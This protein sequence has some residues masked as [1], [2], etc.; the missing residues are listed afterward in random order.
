MSAPVKA[1]TLAAFLPQIFARLGDM[2]QEAQ[3]GTLRGLTLAA[4]AAP[5][6][7]FKAGALYVAVL[8]RAGQPLP[9]AALQQIAGELGK[10][11]H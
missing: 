1:E 4:G 11:N 9:E 3:L 5:C 8:G 6:A 10:L 2:A 7:I